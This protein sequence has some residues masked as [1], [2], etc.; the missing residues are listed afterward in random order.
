MLVVVAFLTGDVLANQIDQYY[1]PAQILGPNGCQAAGCSVT[2]ISNDAS[3][4][5]IF[6]AGLSGTL[7]HVDLFLGSFSG[8][9]PVGIS[10]YS[11]SN[12]T[13]SDNS[14]DLLANTLLPLSMIPSIYPGG[15]VSVDFSTLAVDL[16]KGS[17][18]SI[19]L[20]RSVFDG[21]SVAWWG[22][23]TDP[24]T[25]GN[26]Y[27][28]LTF[29]PNAGRW[30]EPNLASTGEHIDLGFRTIMSS[31]PEPATLFLL[32]IGLA[33]LGFLRLMAFP[34]GGSSPNTLAGL[35]YFLH[36]RVSGL[37]AWYWQPSPSFAEPEPAVTPFQLDCAH[38]AEP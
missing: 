18:Y 1:D 9:V 32:S 20:S 25:G 33:G 29:G 23:A 3:A 16:E 6:T 2:S 37:N 36:C 13:P 34:S 35:L 24:Y 38:E 10:I 11:S 28:K 8:T 5:Q 12:G 26:F 22:S 14:S 17:I 4:A 15:W 21:S 19:V 27:S 7:D 31:V 30:I